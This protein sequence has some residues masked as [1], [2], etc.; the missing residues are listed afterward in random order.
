MEENPWKTLDSKI[1][2]ENAWIRVREDEVL[3]PDG[4]PGIYGVVETRIATA[5]V[6]MNT[7]GEVYLIGQYRYPHGWYSWEL[8]EGGSDEG[9]T[10]LEA[11]QRELK[12]EAGLE[13]D[14]WVQL[15]GDIHLSNCHSSEVAYAF[16]AT[17]LKEGES[18]PDPTEKLQIKK[19]PLEEALGLVDSGQIKDALTI[20]ALERAWKH[21]KQVPAAMGGN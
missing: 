4:K 8:P 6:A 21:L 18:A 19:L 16:L 5:A 10:A 9:E 1:V 20:I 13:A 15:G 14:S 17:G 11:I 3:R 2:Y 7:E 12:E